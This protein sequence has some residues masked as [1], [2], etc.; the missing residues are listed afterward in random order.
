MWL[1]TQ[2]L[3]TKQLCQKLENCCAKSY[4]VKQIVSTHAIKL[5]LPEDIWVHLMFHVNLLEP[6]ATEPYAGHI[7]PL[8][9]P[10]EVDNEVE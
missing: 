8:L 10:I 3:F 1:N 2:N 4:L 9:P 6:I 7:Q 5:T